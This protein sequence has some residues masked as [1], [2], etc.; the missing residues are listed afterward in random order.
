MFSSNLIGSD[1]RRRKGFERRL[2]TER[3]GLP[4][5]MPA[6]SRCQRKSARNLFDDEGTPTRRASESCLYNV[7][8]F[9]SVSERQFRVGCVLGLG[10]FEFEDF[11]GFEYRLLFTLN[12]DEESER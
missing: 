5:D 9:L 12:L 6:R 2:E 4:D 7:A 8:V 11:F 3:S 10:G 1:L